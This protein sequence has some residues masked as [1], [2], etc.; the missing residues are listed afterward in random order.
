MVIEDFVKYPIDTTSKMGNYGN[1]W[2]EM[3][4]LGH[5][6]F[7]WGVRPFAG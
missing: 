4:N 3:V 2:E 1:E 5:E 7:P 6:T